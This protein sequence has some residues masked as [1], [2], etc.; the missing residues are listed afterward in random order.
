[1]VFSSNIVLFI[2]SFSIV[3]KSV[4]SCGFVKAGV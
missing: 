4:V 1:M 3:S 2:G